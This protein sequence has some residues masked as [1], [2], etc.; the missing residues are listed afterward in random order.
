MK[1]LTKVT[2]LIERRNQ[3]KVRHQGCTRKGQSPPLFLK[4]IK[5]EN[6][7]I[8]NPESLLNQ[9]YC[10]VLDGHSNLVTP[11]PIP[12]TEVKQF[13]FYVLLPTVGSMKAV[14]L[15]Y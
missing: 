9:E 2:S 14:L 3:T 11:V 4:E 1:L 15:F 13:V 10:I 6:N 5:C 7:L 8:F 12:N